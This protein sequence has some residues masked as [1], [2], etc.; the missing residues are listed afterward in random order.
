MKTFSLNDICQIGIFSAVICILAQIAIPMPMGI[1]M[2]LQTFAIILT[3][4]V[5]G[6]RKGTI[7]VFIYLLLGC[8]GLPVFANLNGGLNILLGPTGGFLLTFPVMAYLTGR[9]T[10]TR[11]AKICFPL[12]LLFSILINF[13]G[14]SLFFSWVTSSSMTSALSVCV[15][16]FI[17]STIIS[18]I[19]SSVIGWKLRK[20][21]YLLS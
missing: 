20:R 9:G 10:E 5:L 13:L 11:Q 19:L 18:S 6:Y 4:I 7:A 12:M 1:P 17:P 14:G 16:P 8:I 3:A 2:T 21:L 15:L